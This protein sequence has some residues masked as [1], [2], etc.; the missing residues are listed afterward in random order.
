MNIIIFYRTG[1]SSKSSQGNCPQFPA[2]QNDCSSSIVSGDLH[3][4]T[5]YSS[6][7]VLSSVPSTVNSKDSGLGQK[8]SKTQEGTKIVYYLDGEKYPYQ[9]ILPEKAVCLRQFK[10]LIA[11]KKGD[12]R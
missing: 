5:M 2:E 4:A 3:P 9:S 10:E 6:S 11:F 12:Y 8:N 1:L 7:S